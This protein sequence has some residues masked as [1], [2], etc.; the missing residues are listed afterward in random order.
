[1]LSGYAL[2]YGT[3]EDHITAIVIWF[4]A[5]CYQSYALYGCS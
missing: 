4:Y 2:I 5:L 1:V 3:S